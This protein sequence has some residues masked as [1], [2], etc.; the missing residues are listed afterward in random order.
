MQSVQRLA[1]G[2]IV[3]E[4][5]PG[6]GEVFRTHPDRPWGQPSLLY[7]GYQVSFPGVKQPGMALTTQP[8]LAPRLKKEQSCTST[9]L[10]GFHGLFQGVLYLHF[11]QTDSNIEHQIGRKVHYLLFL[12][13]EAS[14]VTF[15]YDFVYVKRY[16][17]P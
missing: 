10:L 3:R 11:Y 14:S 15:G 1:T 4:L 2:W 8:H 7:N 16:S 17:I 5:I 6:G 9:I 13:L 12:V